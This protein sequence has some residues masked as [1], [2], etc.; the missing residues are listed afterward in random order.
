M[1]KGQ[2]LNKKRKR[3]HRFGEEASPEPILEPIHNEW[4]LRSQLGQD[5]WVAQLFKRKGYF[6]EIGA[7]DG[8]ELSNTFY[9]EME[10]KW[11]G[12]LVEPIQEFWNNCNNCRNCICENV[13]ISEKAGLV[14]F[15]ED[16]QSSTIV[17]EPGDGVI[18][19]P[20]ITIKDLFKKYKAPTVIDYLSIDTGGTELEIISS[21]PFKE[22][23]FIA[24]T[25]QHNAYMGVKHFRRRVEMRELLEKNGMSFCR[26][27]DCDDFYINKKYI[28]K[29]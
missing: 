16:G 5:R 9:L 19:I 8:E 14:S 17:Q 26:E 11:T 1:A 6:V 29:L 20:A 4:L 27:S 3:I 24:L 23:S 25:I 22:Y 15:K 13:A 7:W 18:T 12:I 21:F 2:P 10:L 28:G